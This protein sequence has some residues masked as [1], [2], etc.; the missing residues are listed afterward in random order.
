MNKFEEYKL[1]NRAQKMD[2]EALAMIYD[3]L[4]PELYSYSM[5]MTGD[6]QVSEDCVADIFTS[7]LKALGKKQGPRNYLRAY[8]YRMAHNW[9]VD[10]YRHKPTGLDVLDEYLPADPAIQ[11]A[12]RLDEVSAQQ[13]IRETLMKLTDDQRQV[14]VLRFLEGW[15]FPEIAVS[16]KK[17]V[18][19]VKALLHRG[20]DNLKGM[21]LEKDEVIN[22]K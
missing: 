7:L 8:L 10:Y 15:E 18:G 21:L 17:S 19:A 5:K 11:P 4:S 22:E 14:V 3:S 13:K 2:M 9:I 1:L 20:I 6:I 12:N 16:M